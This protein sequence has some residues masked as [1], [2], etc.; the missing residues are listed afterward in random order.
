MT[1][2]VPLTL[3]FA[4]LAGDQAAHY[5]DEDI[6]A[7]SPAFAQVNR[8]PYGKIPRTAILFAYVR[9][10]EDGTLPGTA[11]GVRKLVELSG[12]KALVMALANPSTA[13]INS[14]KL[15][16]PKTANIVFTINRNGSGFARFFR[17]MFDLMRGGTDMLQA[18][19]RLAP[20]GPVQE[21]WLPGTIL[22]AEGGKLLFPPSS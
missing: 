1:K 8:A 19:V 9:L 3:G 14:G 17:E 6:A 21:K 13:I 16:G 22:A 2:P 20:Q 15:P 11:F 10:K 7:L 4:N 18:Y 5:V 12:A